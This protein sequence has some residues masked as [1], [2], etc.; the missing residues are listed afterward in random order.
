MKDFEELLSYFHIS[1][2]HGNTVQC[3]CPGHD[4]RHASLT[5]TDKGDKAL[6]FCHS[7]CRTIDV[8]NSVGLKFGDLFY[9]DDRT[10]IR[11]AHSYR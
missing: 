2:R 6:M 3:R 5:I 7:G 4:D 8:L 9:E 11:R 1:A 10:E